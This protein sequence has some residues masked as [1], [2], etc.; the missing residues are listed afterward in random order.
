[1]RSAMTHFIDWKRNSIGSKWERRAGRSPDLGKLADRRCYN[2]DISEG[3][4][5]SHE[6]TLSRLGN[7]CGRDAARC[8]SAMCTV[9]QRCVEGHLRTIG[10]AR[11]RISPAKDRMG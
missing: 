3:V 7:R 1:M 6:Y 5:P 4:A 10:H 2:S 8:C 9:A 11:Q